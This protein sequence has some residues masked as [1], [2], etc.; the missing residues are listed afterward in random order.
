MKAV[1][2][3]APYEIEIQEK[4][5]P[6]L[7][8]DEILI[9][10]SAVAIC[11]SDIHAYHGRQALFIYPRVIGHEICGTVEKINNPS[12][13]FQLGDKVVV[14]PYSHCGNCIACKKGKPGCCEELKVMGVHVD[15]GLAEYCAIKECY[16]LKVP[17]TIDSTSLSLVEPLAISAHAV[18]N[19]KV[20]AGE[21]VLVMGIGPIGMGAAEISKTY[22]ANVIL[23]D[24]SEERR[25]FA[26]KTLDY[27]NVLN[28]LDE[29]FKQDL[30]TLTK[31]NMPDTIIDATGNG[32]S[33][34]SIFEYLSYGG[35]VVYVGISS[36]P[37]T[38]NH[39]EFHKRQ[40]ELYS[41]RA[42]TRYDFEYVINCIHEG[43][44]NPNL[45]ITDIITLDANIKDE[46]K[47]L[48]DK[49]SAMFKGIIAL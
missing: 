7:K 20:Q 32:K 46:F 5:I 35:K 48:M 1:C 42:A 34:S 27:S 3:K 12:S 21:N 15:G 33:M 8:D 23:A 41:S 40:T 10:V 9:K 14:I 30:A 16:L 29:T 39:V 31:G 26:K 25:A 24:I 19:A 36:T 11:G 18:H 45:F 43:T 13:S 38:I 49:S 6:T 44:L 2:F 4:D 37:L 47:R 22:N 28:P 17:N